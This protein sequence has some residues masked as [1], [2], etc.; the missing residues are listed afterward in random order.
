MTKV[1]DF[2]AGILMDLGA[3]SI[4]EFLKLKKA[5][6]NEAVEFFHSFLISFEDKKRVIEKLPFLEKTKLF[7]YQLTL[8]KRWKFV[9]EIEISL[10]KLLDKKENIVRG[11]IYTAKPI[12]EENKKEITQAV[13]KFFKETLILTTQVDPC[14]HGGIRVEASGMSF[15]DT[16][17]SHLENFKNQVMKS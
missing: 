14:L 4:E 17:R 8:K 1:G 2:Y 10:K 12:S 13:G 6:N 15:D 9:E 11:V 7:L 5:L 16:G 3:K